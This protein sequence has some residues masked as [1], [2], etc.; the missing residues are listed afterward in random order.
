[1]EVGRTEALA[2]A[3]LLVSAHISR[4]LDEM[5][6]VSPERLIILS[7]PS[8]PSAVSSSLPSAGSDPHRRA[9]IQIQTARP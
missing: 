8:T 5:S 2:S 7:L 3:G 9:H 4:F 6:N 1:M